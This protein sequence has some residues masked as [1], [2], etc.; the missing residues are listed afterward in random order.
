MIELL[1]GDNRFYLLDDGKEIGEITYE[2][3]NKILIVDHTFVDPTYRG[4]NL[5]IKLVD[6]VSDYA[7]KVGMKIIPTCSYVVKV[8]ERSVDYLDVW[9]KDNQGRD[10]A[11][12]LK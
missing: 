9:E 4:Q 12:K 8:F 3:E 11:C 7:R 6:A 1:K 10:V 2:V 5:A